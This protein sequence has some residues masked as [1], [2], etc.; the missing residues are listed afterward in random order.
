MLLNRNFVL[1]VVSS[2]VLGAPMPMLILLGALA[3]QSLAPVAALATLP[4]SIQILAGIIVA[5]PISM[6]MGKAGRRKGFLAGAVFM[7]AGGLLAALALRVN[8]FI[9]LCM[10]HF[11]LGAAFISLNFFRFA[12]A[13]SVP[14]Q[15]K[16][17]AI[18]YTLASG[19]LAAFIGPLIYTHF[20][21]ALLPIPFAGAYLAL[22]G[23]GLLG[24]IPLSMLSKMLPA[25]NSTVASDAPVVSKWQVF[26]RP[27]V[28]LALLSAAV[29]QASMVLLMIPTPL[30]MEAHGHQGH[31][32]A[33]VIRWHVIAMFAPGFFTGSL[34]QRFGS[35]PI[36]STGFLL[37][38]AAG[39]VAANGISLWNFYLSLVLLGVGWN[40][41]FIGGTHLLQ[42]AVSEQE[43]PLIQGVNDTILAVASSVASLSAGALYTGFGWR[44]L[45]I[46][47]VAALLIALVILIV[48]QRSV[49]VRV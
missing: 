25:Q 15:W 46:T 43:R 2:I 35:G 10:A 31:L 18:S 5:I 12:A 22:S 30:A 27:V 32:G 38:I 16:A 20:K 8:S 48:G 6:Y 36:I 33:D 7:I 24:C 47:T 21:D 9:V 14:P 23:L 4:A 19:L 37:L 1:I 26:S 3:G 41:G 34:I 29:A 49:T 42:S 28:L 44:E 39:L 13:E 17:K 11:I 40:F 45:A